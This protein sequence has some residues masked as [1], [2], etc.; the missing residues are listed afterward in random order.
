VFGYLAQFEHIPQ[1]NY[2]IAE[3]RKVTTGPVGVGTSYRQM[4]TVPSRSEESFEVVE[5]EPD[6]RLAIRGQLGPLAGV[7]DYRLVRT[8]EKTVLT[9]TCDLS[10]AGP[11][12]LLA[13]IATRQVRS[14]V[15]TNLNAL[16]QILEAHHE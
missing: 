9:N 10:A 16:K 6:R 4:R 1:W 5:F 8:G 15:A 7:I 2:T 13:P 12:N 11:L 14:A 3:T